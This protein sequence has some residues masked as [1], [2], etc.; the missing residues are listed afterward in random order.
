MRRLLLTLES[1]A[2]NLALDE[3]LLDR[4]EAEGSDAE[5]LRMWESPQPVVVLGR[6][7]RVEQEID[8]TYCAS[9]GI[10]ILRRSSGGAAIVAGPGCL[11][12]AVVLSYERRPQM[13]GIP[14]TH[15]YVLSRIAD[16][17]KCYVPTVQHAGTSDLAFVDD[18][19]AAASRSHNESS[20]LPVLSSGITPLRKFSGNSLRVKR[21]HCLYHGT[22]LYDF[23]LSLISECL[24]MP[25]RR[26]EYRL[27]RGHGE[28]IANLPLGKDSLQDALLAAWPT[29]GEVD[30]W[31]RNR[32]HELVAERYGRDEWNLTYGRTASD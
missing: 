7:S 31:P 20:Q 1:P 11:M 8:S 15:C 9:R 25:A 32:V 21:T 16:C 3:A 22:L 19:S 24:T 18:S 27:S 6:S 4:A 30:D 14:E 13:R 28:F 12:Y 17:L 10:P 29:S 2:E 23:D 26:P 5:Y